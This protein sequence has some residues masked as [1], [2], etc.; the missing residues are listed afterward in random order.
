MVGLARHGGTCMPRW[1]GAMARFS[2]GR[3]VSKLGLHTVLGQCQSS[4][5]V[6]LAHCDRVVAV[7]LHMAKGGG[8]G[9]DLHAAR[10]R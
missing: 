3:L 10:Q 1:G 2:Q 5:T 8:R 7:D 4:I 9:H 6:S